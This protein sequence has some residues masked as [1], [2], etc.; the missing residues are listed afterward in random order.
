MGQISGSLS[1]DMT[2]IQKEIT[3]AVG[4]EVAKVVMPALAEL[5]AQMT[6]L[7]RIVTATHL[8]PGNAAATLA[9]ALPGDQ[10]TVLGNTIPGREVGLWQS[11]RLAEMGYA[12]V[13]VTPI[14]RLATLATQPL[15]VPEGVDLGVEAAKIVEQISGQ[16][17]VPNGVDDWFE[18]ADD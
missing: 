3:A 10:F 15:P 2:K 5:S 12:L 6:T 4:E 7:H 13:P 8:N 16:S 14:T 11:E 9:S 1:L 18:R 17:V